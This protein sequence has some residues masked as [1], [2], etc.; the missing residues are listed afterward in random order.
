MLQKTHANAI[1]SL[2]ANTNDIFTIDQATAEE[3]RDFLRS[4]WHRFD[5]E[6]ERLISSCPETAMDHPYF[7]T[8][9]SH[10]LGHLFRISLCPSSPGSS[11]NRDFSK[12]YSPQW[13]EIIQTSHLWI[14][15]LSS[16]QSQKQSGETDNQS[17][18]VVKFI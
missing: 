12:T 16:Q 2:T 14:D 17:K 18:A 13:S 6:H 7:K 15:A 8:D 3:T 5:A 1:A 9:T 10:N 11:L 4:N